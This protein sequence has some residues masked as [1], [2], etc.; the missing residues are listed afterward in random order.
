VLGW[1]AL[2]PLVILTVTT[3]AANAQPLPA[4][5]SAWIE[6]DAPA[7]CDSGSDELR[8]RVARALIGPRAEELSARVGIVRSSLGFDV[9][10]E[11]WRGEASAGV[12]RLTASTCDE[13]LDAAVIV[14]AQALADPDGAP[15]PPGTSRSEAIEPAKQHGEARSTTAGGAVTVIQTPEARPWRD[16]VPDLSTRAKQARSSSRTAERRIALLGGLDAGT[17]PVPAPY[18]AV[19]VGWARR[20]IEISLSLRGGV[21]QKSIEENRDAA[22]DRESLGWAFGGFDL[23]ACYGSS[24]AWRLAA[25]LGGEAGVV[26]ATREVELGGHVTATEVNDPFIAGVVSTM[27]AHRGGW[28]QPVLELG[29]TAVALGP[30]RTTSRL[31]VRAAGGA[32]LQF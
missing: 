14:L 7:A 23:S 26:H 22:L 1:F 9:A 15:P 32:A 29:A 2:V 16:P 17:L 18:V 25:C 13:A 5:E 27:V 4:E 28:M 11:L 3:V 30:E 8:D 12:K 10:I 24:G 21:P 6:L 31:G 20:Q 19:G